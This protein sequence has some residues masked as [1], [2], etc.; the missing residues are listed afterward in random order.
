MDTPTPTPDAAQQDRSGWGPLLKSPTTMPP[1]Q[2]FVS[3]R[4]PRTRASEGVRTQKKT[5]L[6][7]MVR[8]SSTDGVKCTPSLVLSINRA[9]GAVLYTAVLPRT[10]SVSSVTKD[11]QS[12]TSLITESS[13]T[14][15][16][17]DDVFGIGK[18]STQTKGGEVH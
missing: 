4:E 2:L 13:V 16:D 18:C 9:P 17:D 15:N 12:L 8:S 7:G 3:T 1:Q 10:A 6:H 5:S 14:L 11:L